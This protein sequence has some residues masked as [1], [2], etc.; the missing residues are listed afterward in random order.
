[1]NK[2]INYINQEIKNT[3]QALQLIDKLYDKGNFKKDC[4]VAQKTHFSYLCEL[5]RAFHRLS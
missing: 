2:V 3:K 4:V 1:M 5:K